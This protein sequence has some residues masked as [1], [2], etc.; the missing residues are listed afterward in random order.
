MT[1]KRKIMNNIRKEMLAADR[2]KIKSFVRGF[3]KEIQRSK[4]DLREL[5]WKVK[6]FL[7]SL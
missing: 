4:K 1:D 5:E 3:L 6:G 7:Y 2:K